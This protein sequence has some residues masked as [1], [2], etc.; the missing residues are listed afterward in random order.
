MPKVG[1]G[2]GDWLPVTNLAE[3]VP[4][5]PKAAAVFVMLFVRCLRRR[6]TQNAG[7][8]IF[9]SSDFQ[10]FPGVYDPDPLNSIHVHLHQFFPTELH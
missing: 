6:L 7:N 2:V 5:P 4:S 9:E 1:P 8:G 3:L 10:N